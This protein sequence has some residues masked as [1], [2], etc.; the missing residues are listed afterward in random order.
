MGWLWKEKD[1]GNPFKLGVIG[2]SD[3]HNSSGSY[4]E[5]K[6]FGTT[7]LTGAPETRASVPINGEYGDMRT[8]QFGA[9][10]LAGVWAEENTR[11]AIFN[12]LKKK[13]DLWD[14]R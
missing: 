7:P 6:Y 5:D 1:R 9:S 11:E 2:S 10:G 13:R 4:E 3:N 12:A 8:A 14:F